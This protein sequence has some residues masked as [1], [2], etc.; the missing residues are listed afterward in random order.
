[1]K[2]RLTL[3]VAVVATAMFSLMPA[4]SAETVCDTGEEYA[5]VH[6]RVLAEDG[7]LGQNNNPG[8]HQG[9]AGVPATGCGSDC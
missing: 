7:A 3:I 1:M 6:I 5:Q 8:S 9:F 4:A 2:R